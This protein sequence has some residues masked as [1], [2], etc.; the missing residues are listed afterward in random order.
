MDNEDIHNLLYLAD[1]CEEF[2]IQ[3]VPLPEIQVRTTRFCKELSER[4]RRLKKNGSP[5]YP[6]VR[7]ESAKCYYYNIL[8]ECPLHR[9]THKNNHCAMVQFYNAEKA[10]LCCNSQPRMRKRLDFALDE[11][12]SDALQKTLVLLKLEKK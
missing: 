6:F 11:N 12:D 8:G 7:R 5:L 1:L 2:Y 3:K 10:G 4:D 9:R